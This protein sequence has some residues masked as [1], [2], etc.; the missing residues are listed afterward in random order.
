MIQV[1]ITCKLSIYQRYTSGKSSFQASWCLLCFSSSQLSFQ[2]AF[3]WNTLNLNVTVMPIGRV[4]QC[5]K[6]GDPVGKSRKLAFWI[7]SAQDDKHLWHE[8]VF[9]DLVKC[10]CSLGWRM[11]AH[12]LTCPNSESEQIFLLACLPGYKP[13]STGLS[14]HLVLYSFVYLPC[15]VI[16]HLPFYLFCLHGEVGKILQH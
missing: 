4:Y 5:H 16:L 11:Q 7:F 6:L 8:P 13:L 12:E 14:D 15:R 2:F 3:R 1:Y 9:K 10:K